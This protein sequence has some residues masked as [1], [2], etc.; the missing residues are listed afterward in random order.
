MCDSVVVN[1]LP[2]IKDPVKRANL[3]SKEERLILRHYG[4]HTYETNKIQFSYHLFNDSLSHCDNFTYCLGPIGSR[5]KCAC[6]PVH[7][8]KGR[9]H[10]IQ[11]LRRHVHGHLQSLCTSVGFQ[12]HPEMKYMYDL[13][14]SDNAT[15]SCVTRTKHQLFLLFGNFLNTLK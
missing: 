14:F 6:I 7:C 13:F 1:L 9:L 5:R 4:T 2:I 10:Q 3:I 12:N 8:L 11:K 15:N